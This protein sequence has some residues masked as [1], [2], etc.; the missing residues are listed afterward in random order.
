[1]VKTLRTTVSL[2]DSRHDIRQEKTDTP[3]NPSSCEKCRD[4]EGCILQNDT[5]AKHC[6][7]FIPNDY[8]LLR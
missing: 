5:D 6:N 3:N 1:M 4:Y 2:I 7:F 8:N